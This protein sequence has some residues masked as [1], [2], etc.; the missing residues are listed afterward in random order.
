MREEGEGEKDGRSPDTG[1][2]GRSS[3]RLDWDRQVQT[4]AAAPSALPGPSTLP[5]LPRPS[6]HRS[7]HLSV[8]PLSSVLSG[9]T[10]GSELVGPCWGVSPGSCGVSTPMDRGVWV[11]GRELA[12]RP[13][14]WSSS[15]IAVVSVSL[16]CAQQEGWKT[17]SAWQFTTQYSV[18]GDRNMFR[19]QS[20]GVGSTRRR[21]CCHRTKGVFPP[22]AGGDWRPPVLCPHSLRERDRPTER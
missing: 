8:S 18:S 21:G 2:K 15:L 4:A 3:S 10:R 9:G 11:R 22:K 19:P 17:L 7:R 6:Q 1:R 16:T 14:M 5:F 13:L 20:T 12:G